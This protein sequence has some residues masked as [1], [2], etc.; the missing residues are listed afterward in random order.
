MS[1]V[2]PEQRIEGELRMR[3]GR[4]ASTSRPMAIRSLDP[5]YERLVDVVIAGARRHSIDMSPG[6]VKALAA[7]ITPTLLRL[8]YAKRAASP[9]ARPPSDKRIIQLTPR[10]RQVLMGLARGLSAEQTGYRLGVSKDTVKTHLRHAYAALGARNG[11]HAVAICL[12]YDLLQA[13]ELEDV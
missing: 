8:P 7:Y 6:Q 9:G 2:I 3:P 10:E 11:C 1:A 4:R 5:I 13:E 12:K